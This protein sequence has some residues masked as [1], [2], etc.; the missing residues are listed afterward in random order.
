M[1]FLLSQTDDVF[2]VVYEA[3]FFKDRNKEI[4]IPFYY[5]EEHIVF[6]I[7]GIDEISGEELRESFYYH[8]SDLKSKYLSYAYL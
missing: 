3:K 2:P 4:N 8:I 6:I 7:D 5:S 1:A